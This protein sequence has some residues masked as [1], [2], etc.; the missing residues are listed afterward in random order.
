M[1]RK[2]VHKYNW[3]ESRRG[4][5]NHTII[6]STDVDEDFKKR[7]V[8]FFDLFIS[9][10]CFLVFVFALAFISCAITAYN[11]CDG[12]ISF[13]HYQALT[14]QISDVTINSPEPI[15]KCNGE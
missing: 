13:S 7:T 12:E 4:K 10:A 11:D 2:Y 15:F 1:K 14:L 9:I 8:R 6:N 3:K 5:V